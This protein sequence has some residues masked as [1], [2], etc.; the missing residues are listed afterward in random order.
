[1][2]PKKTISLLIPALS[3]LFVLCFYLHTAPPSVYHGDDGETITALLTL[4]IQH[5]PGYP[6]HAILGKLFTY[7]PLGDVSFKVYLFTMFVS[8][9]NFL[10]V[11]FFSLRISSMA[12]IK[13]YRELT[14]ATAALLFSFSYTIWEQSII[15]K[16]GI[17]A[18]NLFFTILLSHILLSIYTDNKKRTRYLY[19]FSL[20][21]GLSLTH[22]HMSQEILLPLYAFFLFR[23]NAFKGLSLRNILTC[24]ALFICGIFVYF[25]LPARADTAYL[26]WGQPSTFD[27]F[28][29]DVT[30]W[31]YLRSEIT[32]SFTGSIIQ[33]WKFITTITYAYALGGIIF[34]IPGFIVLYKREK[35]IFLL[36]SGIPVLFLFVTA[37]YLNLTKDRLF[38]MET[39]ITPVYFPLSLFIAYGIYHTA[40]KITSHFKSRLP[41]FALFFAA[42]LIVAQI[43]TAFPKLDKSSYYMAYDYNKN[44]LD[45]LEANSIIFTTGDG[46]VFPGWYL[47]YAKK[48][49]PDVTV[50]GSAVLPM[51]WVRDTIKRQNPNVSV[52]VITNENIGTESTGYIINALI[53]MN[54]THYPVY[55]SYNKTEDNALDATL[56]LVPRGIIQKVLPVQYALASPQYTVMQENLWKFYNLRGIFD[57]KSGNN[58]ERG[59]ALYIKDYSISLNS[60]GTFFEDNGMNDMSLKYFTMAHNVEPLDHEYLYNMGNAHFNLNDIK[61]AIEYYKK[62]L[63]IDPLYE[64]GWY[65]L[66]VCYYKD[67]AY[68]ES[69]EAFKKLKD[70]NPSR[71]DVDP[72]IAIT[73]KLSK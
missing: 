19:L 63:A 56:K 29:K 57:R 24:G 31:Q 20:V 64:S 9:V 38:L 13:N 12:G 7:L 18:L 26:N 66:G 23:A 8:L 33:T 5:P 39:Y 52:P 28:I 3:L 16:G 67:G 48:Y 46:I 49:R 25:Y 72:F 40:A 36:L 70:I 61:S 62:C 10:L 44:L 4:G 21:Y 11:Y 51:K 73:E 58:D 15:A 50:V 14:A 17:Y 27:S 65:N 35:N 69:F 53:K 43:I 41:F 45:S 2:Q 22:H 6:L 37:V 1:M 60:S 42:I 55:F 71:T 59:A 68:K 47:K 32:R 54:Y 30:R 34:L